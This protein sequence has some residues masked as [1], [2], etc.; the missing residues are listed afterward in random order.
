MLPR[1]RGQNVSVP[2]SCLPCSQGPD[3]WKGGCVT[4]WH[5]QT[6]FGGSWDSMEPVTLLLNLTTPAW[7]SP[8][9]LT[10][11]PCYFGNVSG[12]LSSDQDSEWVSC[13]AWSK[14]P[15]LSVPLSQSRQEVQRRRSDLRVRVCVCACVCI[16][17]CLLE[18]PG[19]T[20]KPKHQCL[21]STLRDADFIPLQKGPGSN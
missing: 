19:E 2:Q 9:T 13:V 4:R 12:T 18:S 17:A 14:L 16:H 5:P 10:S 21:P 15:A 6:R 1:S 11:E 8:V 20:K 3:C 7:Q